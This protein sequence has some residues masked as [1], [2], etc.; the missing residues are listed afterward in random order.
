M[1]LED[2]TSQK[3]STATDL[4]SWVQWVEDCF[5]PRITSEDAERGIVSESQS[6]FRKNSMGAGN[7]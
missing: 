1:K 5:G 7:G 4:D 2:T 3:S 6:D